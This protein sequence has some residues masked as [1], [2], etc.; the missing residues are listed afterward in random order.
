MI[1]K[2]IYYMTIYMY[3]EHIHLWNPL[4]CCPRSQVKKVKKHREPVGHP[5][6]SLVP[7]QLNGGFACTKPIFLRYSHICNAT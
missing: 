4:T 5:V 1:Y 2:Q 7:W 3:V 6:E